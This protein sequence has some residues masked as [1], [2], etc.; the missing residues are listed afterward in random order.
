MTLGDLIEAYA[1]ALMWVGTP[2][3]YGCVDALLARDALTRWWE[4]EQ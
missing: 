2:A 3:V 4:H 1:A